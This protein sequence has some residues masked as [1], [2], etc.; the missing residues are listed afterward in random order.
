VSKVRSP[1]S[2]ERLA[3]WYVAVGM[4]VFTVAALGPSLVG[5][6][7]LLSVDVIT[8]YF[9][10][11]SHGAHV[12]GHEVCTGDTIDSGMPGI[13][14]IRG[15]LF[16][17]HLPNWQNRVAGGSTFGSLPNLGLLNPLSLPYFIMP[18]WL[19]PAFVKLF[20]LVV[21][22]GGTFLF[23]RRLSVGRA[24]SLLAGFTFA[25]SGFMVMWTNWSQA[26]VAAFIPALFWAT[27]RL[28]QRARATDVV[29]IAFIVGSM[30]LGGF[31]AVTG[32]ALYAAG[33]YLIVRL[34][35]LH[36]SDR[37]A[38]LR[39]LGL[40][41][42]GIV[43]G[44]MVSMIQLLP[45]AVQYHASDL[46][47]RGGLS[48]QSL[49]F[50]GLDT[51]VV[52]NANGLCTGG[53][54][55]FGH[56][57]AVELIAY[58]GSA[59]LV[60]AIVGMAVDLRRSSGRAN[61]LRGVRG[62]FIVTLVVVLLLGW[63]GGYALH[64]VS[65]LPVFDGN[66]IGRIRSLLGFLLAVFV[67]IGFDALIKRRD[68]RDGRAP[69]EDDA[70]DA[71]GHASSKRPIRWPEVIGL[72]WAVFGAAVLAV[73]IKQARSEGYGTQLLHRLVVPLI[74]VALAIGCV[75]LIYWHRRGAN[76]LAIY[77]LPALIIG[78]GF[79]FFHTVLPGDTV[80]NFYPV[81]PTHQFLKANLG[82][83]RYAATGGA[84]YPATSLYYGLRSVT[85]HSFHEPQWQLLLQTIDPTAMASATFSQF[86]GALR[87]ADLAKSK[88]LDRM[89]A[90]YL[91]VD[92]GGLTGTYD[93]LAHGPDTVSLA[94]QQQ[95][96]C[97]LPPGPLR[98]VSIFVANAWVASNPNAGETISVTL[99]A[100]GRTLSSGRF[101]AGV[102]ANTGIAIATAAG[103]FPTDVP[104]TVTVSG[105]GSAQPL[106]LSANKNMIDCAAVRPAD[107]GLNLVFADS[108][109][110]IYQRLTALPRIRWDT[111]TVVVGDADARVGDGKIDDPRLTAM[112]NGLPAG[113]VLLDSAGPSPSG[114][115]ATIDVRID[116]SDRITADVNAA[117]SGYLV[118]ADAMQDKGWT[119]TI[120]GTK[121]KIVNADDAM[122]GVFVPAGQ[123]RVSFSYR[124][125]GQLAGAALTLIALVIMLSISLGA[126]FGWYG[127]SVNARRADVTVRRADDRAESS[128]EAD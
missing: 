68:G 27:E 100:G 46:S 95:V 62:Y 71:A 65:A 70:D 110:I 33:A 98:G 88:I 18:L 123:H 32:W 60:L 121:S 69:D 67:G 52:P 13:S 96:S 90:K 103:D 66:L 22:V 82:G 14:Y 44:L 124:A 17:G 113:A 118:V 55:G 54:I 45:F 79:A 80:K 34:V 106:V 8:N 51:L 58:I 16:S 72:A 73:A 94:P 86:D 111:S 7:T 99:S 3:T 23:L 29:V 42:A 9:P 102:P 19:A 59:A 1:A 109:S 64:L 50:G 116:G 53:S 6:N 37:S 20:E 24:A 49:P 119:V 10:W 41:V 43:L 25:V 120:D 15:Q 57:S 2:H 5:R 81:T 36:R 21:A 74:L 63:G 127:S 47:Y 61:R 104:V 97:T 38:M 11:L 12:T 101:L 56:W 92:P 40:G 115:P 78:Q 75:A 26:V 89:S 114:Q 87:P 84:M 105:A 35:G 122:V 126:R 117:G 28:V 77:V 31:P 76:T 39:R 91:V 93:P 85:G 107:D 125:P 83:E 30:L 128:E 112:A 108:G 48:L 4:F